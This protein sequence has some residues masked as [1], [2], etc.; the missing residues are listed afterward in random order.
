MID[1]KEYSREEI[2]ISDDSDDDP[3][4]IEEESEDYPIEFI[5]KRL[6]TESDKEMLDEVIKINKASIRLSYKKFF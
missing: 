3:T 4:T 6:P 1:P 2:V 5:R